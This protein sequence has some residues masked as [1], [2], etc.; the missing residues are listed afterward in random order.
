MAHRLK[1][2]AVDGL[3]CFWRCVFSVA[4]LPC[5]FLVFCFER[6]RPAAN[7]KPPRLFNLVAINSDGVASKLP[8]LNY[9]YSAGS[10]AYCLSVYVRI[11]SLIARAVPGRF[12]QSRDLYME[13]AGKLGLTRETCFV[14]RH[15]EMVA[16]TRTVRFW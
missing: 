15:L 8:L 6:T 16:A 1:V 14:A 3:L 9:S 12:P 2:V 5:F 7:V 11:T 4:G 10:S 13:L